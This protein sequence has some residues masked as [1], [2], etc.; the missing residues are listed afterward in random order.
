MISPPSSMEIKILMRPQCETQTAL[1]VSDI[2]MS[3]LRLQEVKWQAHS[4]KARKRW[5]PVS[6][7]YPLCP[8]AWLFS[9]SFTHTHL[10]AMGTS[11]CPLGALSPFP[12]ASRALPGG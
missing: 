12:L 6:E 4:H 7:R 2:I 9:S 5:A 11:A 10:W 8:V 1:R 3:G